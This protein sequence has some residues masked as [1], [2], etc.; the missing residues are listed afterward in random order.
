MILVPLHPYCGRCGWRK[1]G[2]D[3]WNGKACKCGHFAPGFLACIPCKYTG[4]VAGVVCSACHGSG[5]V[6]EITHH[7]QRIAQALTLPAE[8]LQQQTTGDRE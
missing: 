4:L 1:G 8:L 2:Q 5:I 6:D 7:Q 3:S